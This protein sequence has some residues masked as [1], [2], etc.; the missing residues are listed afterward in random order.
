MAARF[1]NALAGWVRAG[2]G[3]DAVILHC[4]VIDHQERLYRCPSP[5]RER[6]RDVGNRVGADTDGL[7]VV[8]NAKDQRTGSRM[9]AERH[10]V[11]GQPVFVSESRAFQSSSFAPCGSGS[12]VSSRQRSCNAPVFRC[13]VIV[14]YCFGI[15]RNFRIRM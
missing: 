6:V 5:G 15:F 3:C 12:R 8:V 10:Q 1:N 14:R 13:H 4:G 2:Q 9:V 7:A 11:L